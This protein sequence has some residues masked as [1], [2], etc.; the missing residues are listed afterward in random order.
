MRPV[1]LVLSLPVIP[2]LGKLQP[3]LH[4]LGPA[5]AEAAALPG[6]LVLFQTVRPMRP[7]CVFEVEDAVVRVDEPPPR[8]A[9][10]EEA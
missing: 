2:L 9:E 3:N 7:G 6:V 1:L 5:P 4:L 8:D 10:P